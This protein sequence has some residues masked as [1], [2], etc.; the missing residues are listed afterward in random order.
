MTEEEKL[1]CIKNGLHTELY[2][3]WAKNGHYRI[4]VELAMEGYEHD[5][6]I[7]DPETT[8]RRIVMYG[9]PEYIEKRFRY[10][11]PEDIY[12][13]IRGLVDIDDDILEAQLCYWQSIHHSR[14]EVFLIKKRL[15]HYAPTALETTMT[16][17]QLYK[18]GSPMWARGLDISCIEKI[19]VELRGGFAV[20]TVFTG[21]G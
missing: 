21:V 8:I 9:R 10:E 13:V 5:Q 14:A 7:D 20:E 2:S 19:C 15:R 18:A 12:A 1:E 17:R 3:E 11:E 4:R 16:R 6:L